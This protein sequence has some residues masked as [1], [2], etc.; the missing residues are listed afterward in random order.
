M[1]LWQPNLLRDEIFLYRSFF[2]FASYSDIIIGAFYLRFTKTCLKRGKV[3]QGEPG[4]IAG[5][6]SK[7]ENKKYS[8]KAN[9]EKRNSG[10][11]C[12][13]EEK[14]KKKENGIIGKGRKRN[15][16]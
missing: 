7:K 14:R 12:S 3:V 9:K 13:R 1:L 10:K 11:D 4:F 8:Q 6:K 15:V 2:M 5:E 16:F